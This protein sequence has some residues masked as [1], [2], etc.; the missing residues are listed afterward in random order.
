MRR[1]R[2]AGNRV[3]AAVLAVSMV[4]AYAPAIS[5]AGQPDGQPDGGAQLLADFTF[6]DAETGFAG[7]E[8]KASA[9][10]VYELRDSKDAESGKAL[11][12]NGNAANYLSVTDM[13]GGSLLAGKEEI[14]ISYDEKPDQTGTSWAFYAAPS[15]ATQINQNEHYIGAFH[16]GGNIKIERYNN[17]GARPSSIQQS[18]GTEWAHIDVVFK[19]EETVL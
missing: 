3:L 12:L 14:T 15:T 2:K 11:Y 1:K 18:V 17:A 9:N 5:A 6:D 19:A 8:A 16:N 13:D 4:G 7:G 10:G